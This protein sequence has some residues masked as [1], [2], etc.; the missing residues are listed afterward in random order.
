MSWRVQLPKGRHSTYYSERRGRLSQSRSAYA[1]IAR[2]GVTQLSPSSLSGGTRRNIENRTPSSSDSTLRIQISLFS[3]PTAKLVV[4]KIL[5]VLTR[6]SLQSYRHPRRYILT[7]LVHVPQPFGN[8][9]RCQAHPRTIPF[10][11]QQLR[12]RQQLDRIPVI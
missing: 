1:L 11:D 7:C 2:F 12:S 3:H 9:I 6:S 5:E 10:C 4:R 8:C